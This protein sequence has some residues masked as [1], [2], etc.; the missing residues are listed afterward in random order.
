MNHMIRILGVDPGLRHTGWGVIESDGV[1]LTWVASG[2]ITSDAEDDLA[3]RLR[4]LFE[5]LGSVIQ[6]YSPR[7]AAVWDALAKLLA[8]IREGASVT[9][10]VA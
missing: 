1:R 7:E 2:L 3:Y 5:G 9:E 10:A 4:E 8:D 6:S